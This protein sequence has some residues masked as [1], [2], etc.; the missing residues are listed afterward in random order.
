MNVQLAK[1]YCHG[2]TG[3]KK[4]ATEFKDPPIGWV[5]SEKY[6]GYR[7]LFRYN[8]EGQGE[9]YSRAGKK[10]IAPEWFLQGMPSRNLLKDHVLD[11]ELW[12]GRDNFQL[13]GVVRKKVPLDEEWLNVTFQVYD[14]PEH[15]GTFKERLE[16]LKRVVGLEDVP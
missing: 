16:E 14:M 10:F 2:M 6:D 8:S 12:A 5:M 9:F 4:D 7:A 3:H 1:E 11:G 13:M 15:P